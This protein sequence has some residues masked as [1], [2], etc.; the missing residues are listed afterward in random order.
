MSFD[1]SRPEAG[2]TRLTGGFGAA[3][4]P[5]ISFDGKRILFV[6][7][8][9]RKE[10]FAAWEMNVDGSNLRRITNEAESCLEAI[11]LSTIYTIDDEAPAYQIGFCRRDTNGI[12]ALYTCRMDGTRVA[13]ITFDPYGATD[14]CQLSDGRLLFTGGPGSALLTVNTDGTDVFVF[15]AAHEP[16]ARRGMPCETD[17][18][19]IVYVESRHGGGDLGSALVAVSR[20]ASLHSRRVVADDSVGRYRSPAATDSGAL[21]VSYRARES[22]SYGLHLL[23]PRTG[24]RT[25]EVYDDPR[26]H[27]LDAVMVRARPHPAGRSSVVDE[28]VTRGLLYCLDAHI[29]D[30]EPGG[31]DRIEQLKVYQAVIGQALNPDNAAGQELIGAVPVETDGSF[32][33]S[34]PIR[35][36]LRLETL[37]PDGRVLRTMRSWFWVMP[38]ERRGC[39]GCHE[40]R[41]LSPPNRHPLAVRKP[42]VPVGAPGDTAP[43]TQ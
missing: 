35:T 10:P 38:G 17:D 29:S 25:A 37:G 23:D 5:D 31:A 16:P 33:L 7:R 6:A 2:V 36:P 32:H 18:G 42:P 34:V 26:W 19:W 40:D 3:G 39:I 20:T 30:A 21:L 11:Y 14:P 24:T 13:R 4:R 41:E 27:D 22:D 8:R 28:Q 1:P 15:G 9:S 43:E 12:E